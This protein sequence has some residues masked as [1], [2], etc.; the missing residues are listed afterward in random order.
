MK[1]ISIFSF[2]EKSLPGEELRLR[3]PHEGIVK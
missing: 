1:K 2:R 3:V